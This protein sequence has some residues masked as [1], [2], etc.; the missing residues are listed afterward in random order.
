MRLLPIFL[1]LIAI[2]FHAEPARGVVVSRI[3]EFEAGTPIVADDLNEEF[4]NIIDAINGN[5][6]TENFPNLSIATSNIATASVTTDKLNNGAVTRAKLAAV[7]QSITSSSSVFDTNSEVE[8]EVTNLSTTI[9][10]NGRPV[11]VGLQSAGGTSA[12]GRITYRSNGIAATGSAA[13]VSFRRA[14]ATVN[15]AFVGAHDITA[16][17]NDTNISVPC[18]TFWFLD[19]PASGSQAYT[20]HARTATS[21][22]GFLTVENCKLV[23]FEL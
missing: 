2:F 8:V 1:A 21:D 9:V 23:V 17:T 3:N 7:A 12:P 15:Q 10:S 22:N 13:F 20:T 11:W 16:P 6:T 5:L 19:V 18:S 14:G 4:D